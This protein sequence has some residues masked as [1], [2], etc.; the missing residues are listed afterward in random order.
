[1]D[2]D[3]TFQQR[4][5]WALDPSKNNVEHVSMPTFAKRFNYT[6]E[7][8]AEEAYLNIIGSSRIPMARRRTLIQEY[9]AF[10]ANNS[11]QYWESVQVKGS[12]RSVARRAAVVTA[13]AGLQE[14]QDEYSTYSASPATKTRQSGK[15]KSPLEVNITGDL[16]ANE[17]LR[18]LPSSSTP[19][20]TPPTNSVERLEAEPS[21]E[22]VSTAGR[23]RQLVENA[24]AIFFVGFEP[25]RSLSLFLCMLPDTL[26]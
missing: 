24:P 13:E 2:K 20:S 15:V 21:V 23:Y 22:N 11:K 6:Q 10:K 8:Y 5:E 17:N 7:E 14:A 9:D 26:I 3:R 18:V 25:L 4:L 12:L 16:A 1:M 19:S